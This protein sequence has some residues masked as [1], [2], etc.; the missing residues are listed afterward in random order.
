MIARRRT[1]AGALRARIAC[2]WNNCDQPQ[3]PNVAQAI[4]D[5]ERDRRP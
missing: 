1:D 5:R 3:P 2:V 4:A